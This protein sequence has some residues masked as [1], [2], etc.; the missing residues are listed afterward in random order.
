MSASSS[1]CPPGRRTRSTP[2]TASTNAEWHGRAV[3]LTPAGVHSNAR[4]EGAEILFAR[5]EGPWLIDVEGNRH[6]DYMLGRGPAPIR[7]TPCRSA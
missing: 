6:V 3:G 4:L 7:T 5:G 2:R 1:A